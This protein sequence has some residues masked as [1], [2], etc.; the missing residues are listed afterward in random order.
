VTIAAL[1][2]AKSFGRAKSRLSGVL[3]AEQREHLARACFARVVD[4]LLGAAAFDSVTVCTDG[5]EV[6]AL[7]R[8]LGCEVIRDPAG[9]VAF[10]E[11][12]D[13]ALRELARRGASRA[14][15]VM[16]DLPEASPGSFRPLLSHDARDVVLVPD[17][18]GLGTSALLVP[19]PAP[20]ATAFGNPDSAARHQALAAASG[21][22]FARVHV[23]SLARDVDGPL[24]LV[25]RD[26]LLDGT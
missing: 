10:S 16:A 25:G 21:L 7:A 1:V 8:S 22:R 24:D 26:G 17:A 18:E 20:F 3:R 12:I 23:P 15:V 2:P 6:E 14:L 11:I 19:L 9:P 4:A 5:D 13:A